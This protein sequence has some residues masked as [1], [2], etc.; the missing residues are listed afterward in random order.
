MKGYERQIPDYERLKIH[1]KAC[2]REGA[3][4]INKQDFPVDKTARLLDGYSI[5]TPMW[6]HAIA[7]ARQ[8]VVFF[9]VPR[10]F[11]EGLLAYLP[12][13]GLIIVFLYDLNNCY[14]HLC[15]INFFS[16]EITPSTNSF[17]V[18]PSI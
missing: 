12:S 8:N 18:S 9:F 5:R 17:L 3:M 6:F 16:S 13:R 2:E 15:C 10:G 14:W 11:I 1:C 4:C 7:P